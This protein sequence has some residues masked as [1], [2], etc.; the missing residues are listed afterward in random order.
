MNVESSLKDGAI[1]RPGRS[2]SHEVVHFAGFEVDFDRGELRSAGTVVALRPKTFAL[3]TYLIGRPGQLLSKDQL[4]D[5]VWPDVV[6]TEDSLFQCIGELRAALGDS[7]QK[8]IKT[9]P[10]RGY[11]FDATVSTAAPDKPVAERP[12]PADEVPAP[13]RVVRRPIALGAMVVVL[14]LVVG[15]AAFLLWRPG[16]QLTARNTVAI[17]PLTDLSS[18]SAANLAEAVTED[19]IIDVSRLPDT[20]VIAQSST[21]AFTGRDPDVQGIGR[22]LNASF[23]LSG[24]LRRNGD[25][26]SIAVKLHAADTAAVLWSER[27][28][29]ADNSKWNWQ[30]DI[31]ARIANAL[32]VRM[33]AALPQSET[34]YAGRAAAGIDPMLQGWH[35]LRRIHGRAEP[36]QARTLF[37]QAL[38]IDPDSPEALS[39]LALSHM[40]EVLGR[41]SESPSTQIALAAEA[42]EKALILKP[43]DPRINNIRGL[44]LYAQGKIDEAEK[45]TERALELHP[46]WPRALQRLGFLRLQQGRPAE[47]AAP[48]LMSQRLNPLDTEQMSQS[49]FTLGMAQFH[50]RQDDEAYEQMRQAATLS[51]RN[52]FAWQWMAAIDALRDRPEQ[53]RLNLAEYRKY[54]PGHTVSSLK[55][56]EPSRNAA[57]WA[58]RE[59]F[60]DGLRKAGL[61]E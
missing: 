46:N 54:I 11:L 42:I 48:V 29:Y 4:M 5:A 26:V 58:E 43:A 24:S 36:Q 32:H 8:L 52:G 51:P 50:L 6:V 22:R 1:D 7:A 25:A 56:S 31:T 10:R 38:K 30:R 61:P 12:P 2:P 49:H 3:L 37:E 13:A 47:V 44:V 40:T 59:R 55:A 41:W 9:V 15:A 28:D 14:L 23:V 17:L 18:E 53:A 39:G 20:L 35:L 21:Q 57:F 16:S 45:A 33:D 34:P 60:Y 19:L 27:F